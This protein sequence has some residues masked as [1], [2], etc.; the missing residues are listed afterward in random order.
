[1][2]GEI[3]HVKSYFQ[4]MILHFKIIK[5]IDI[6]FQNNSH[7]TLFLELNMNYFKNLKEKYHLLKIWFK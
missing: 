5:I 1:M 4:R 3:R 2:F 6:S 7:S